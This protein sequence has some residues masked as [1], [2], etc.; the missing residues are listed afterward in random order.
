MT[1]RLDKVLANAGI[2]TR[3]EVKKY[4]RQKR[5]VINRDPAEQP[6]QKVGEIDE[7]LF[8]GLPVVTEKYVYYMLYKP[9]GVVT[10]TKDA[11]ERTVLDLLD[12][13]RKE[14]LFPVG[15][16][17]KDTE[18]LLLIT[19]D[20]DLSHRL[21]AP[22]KHVPKTYEAMV[23]GRMEEEWISAFLAGLDIGDEKK[24]APAKLEILCYEKEQDLTN[25]RLTITEG[26][27]HQVKRMCHAAGHK[28]LYLKRLSMGS[29]VLDQSLKKG[30]YRRLSTEEIN[31]LK[32]R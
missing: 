1:E 19:N 11:R 17:D 28:V 6:Q 25:I 9:A 5:I 22:G 30:E 8:D 16:L 13:L 27:Y 10:A 12:V 2:G 4:I 20:G 23:K 7:V 3:S 21:L 18:G 26:R 32:A 15:R 31:R 24:T 29:L 14:R